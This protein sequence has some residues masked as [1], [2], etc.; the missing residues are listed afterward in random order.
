MKIR[1][2]NINLV[3]P[4]VNNWRK[5]FI[6]SE[7]ILSEHFM[8]ATILPVPDQVQEQVPRAI[9]QS[10]HGHSVLN[11]ALNVSS[12]TTTYTDDY[13]CNWK[14]CEEYLAARCDSVYQLVNQL[15]DGKQEFVGLVTTIE[16][17]DINEPSIEILKKSLLNM[18]GSNLGDI[19]DISC[20]LTYVYL[21][22]Y[23]V[24]LTLEN[25]RELL[26]NQRNDGVIIKTGNSRNS[27]AV[28]IDIN[29]RFAANQIDGYKSN[30]SAF[31]E[32][33]RLTADIIKNKLD[34]LIKK[35]EFA[36]VGE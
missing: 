8:P 29:D 18:S 5:K 32:I 35:G 23:Y 34:I 22:K 3:Y 25:T 17:D 9:I 10:K 33:L 6:L 2:T 16:F 21:N 1:Q 26:M 36:Y 31:E 19:Y 12:F 20:K 27:I 4:K 14:L 11:V 7:S 15:S 24:N 28:T 30:K 13:I